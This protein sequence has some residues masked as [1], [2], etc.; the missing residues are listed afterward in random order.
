MA[1]RPSVKVVFG[2]NGTA[3]SMS[4]SKGQPLHEFTH[5]AIQEFSQAITESF[6]AKCRKPKNEHE[7]ALDYLLEHPVGDPPL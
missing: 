1:S 2:E 7:G 3:K 6:R 5:S 4:T